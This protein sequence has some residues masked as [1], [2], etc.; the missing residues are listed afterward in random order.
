M[1]DKSNRKF[2]QSAAHLALQVE[3][4]DTANSANYHKDQGFRWNCKTKGCTQESRT[5]LWTQKV[6]KG[7]V[8]SEWPSPVRGKPGK[9]VTSGDNTKQFVIGH[10]TENFTRKLQLI[11]PER[12]GQLEMSTQSLNWKLNLQHRESKAIRKWCHITS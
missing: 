1:K 4:H 12:H 8:N 5:C 9:V 6:I 11:R 10:I 7:N 2:L 3:N